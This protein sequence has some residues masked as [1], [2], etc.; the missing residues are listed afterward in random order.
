MRSLDEK[1]SKELLQAVLRRDL[2]GYEQSSALLV[3]KC[4]GH[5][6]ALFS[7]ANYLQKKSKFTETDCKNFWSD[8]GSHMAEEYAFRKL[9]QVLLN[10]YRSLPGRPVDLKTRL[11]YVCVFPN[12]HPIRRSTLMRRWLAE[13]CIKDADPGKALLVADRS[14]G[15]LVDR[16][17]IRP[18][19]P[20]SKSAKLKTCR[21]HGIMHEFMLHMSMSAKFITSLGDPQRSNYRHLFMGGR[22]ATSS[23]RVPNVNHRHISPTHGGKPGDEKLRAHSLAICGS[24]GEA[25]V[26]FANCELLRVLDLEE[27]KD[28]KDDHMDGIHKLWHLKYLSLGAAISRL[29]RRIEK[30]Q[31]LETLDMRNAMVEII[32][33]VEVLKLPHLAHILGK[34]KLGKRDWKMSE[35]C[36]LLPKESNSQTLAGFVTD[37]NPGFPMLMVRMKKLR[38]LCLSSTNSLMSTD[39]VNLR[40]LIHLEYLKLVRVS[41]GGFTIRRQDFPRLLRLCLVQGPT[42]PTIEGGALR[43]LISRQLLSEDLGDVSGIGIGRHEHLQEVALDSKINKEAKTVWEDAA[44]KHPRRPRGLY[45]K[46]VDPQGMGSLVKCVAAAREPEHETECA[47]MQEM[48]NDQ[49]LPAAQENRGEVSSNFCGLKHGKRLQSAGVHVKIKEPNHHI[50]DEDDGEDKYFQRY[51][52]FSGYQKT[53]VVIKETALDISKNTVTNTA[54]RAVDNC[55]RMGKRKVDEIPENAYDWQERNLAMKLGPLANTIASPPSSVPGAQE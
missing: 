28:L 54:I 47:V 23:G 26:D 37:N 21:A 40:K 44:K 13:G 50:G 9:Q 42:L 2:P 19:D 8:L 48:M 4:D 5:P 51:R 52:R 33:P 14:L 25:A 32:L 46:R 30:L 45:L 27:C 11:L 20:S 31:C 24:A 17:I 15:E 38:K 6:L 12:G 18:I 3:N 34:F 43:N 29:P 22:P 41:L 35:S 55:R 53:G 1:H 7:V 16:N 10:N 49:E 36:K 39:I